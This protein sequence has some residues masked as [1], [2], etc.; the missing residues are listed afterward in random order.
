MEFLKESPPMWLIL[1][2]AVGALEFAYF[3]NVP[4]VAKY[5]FLVLVG[6]IIVGW[7]ESMRKKRE[8]TSKE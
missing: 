3:G 4:M 8:K 6:A 1:T 5:G 7:I 2:L